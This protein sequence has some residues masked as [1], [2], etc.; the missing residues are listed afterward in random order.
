MPVFTYSELRISHSPNGMCGADIMAHNQKINSGLKRAVIDNQNIVNNSRFEA[1]FDNLLNP[2]DLV[3]NKTGGVIFTEQ[4]GS[5]APL[6]SPDLS[7]LT[8]NVLQMMKEDGEARSGLSSLTKGMNTAV[9]E[10]QNAKDMVERLTNAAGARPSADARSFAQSFLIPL[11]RYLV[12]Y[13]A[14]WDYSQDQTEASGQMIP[15]I[16][17]SWQ[18]YE[19]ECEVTVALTPDES[20]SQAQMLLTM[21]QVISQDPVASQLYGVKER[22]AMFDDIFDA[23]GVSDTQRYM[24]RPDSPEF[25]A[26]NQQVMELQQM[27]QMLQEQLNGVQ[28]WAMTQQVEQGWAQINNTMMDKMEDNVRQDSELAME[29]RQGDRKLD[30]EEMKAKKTN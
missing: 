27:V 21:H 7:P 15:I 2:R 14:Q 5:V 8:F 17:Q 9:L 30:I 13:A 26:Q 23:M 12:K 29:S 16:P 18:G 22:H 24:M 28:T 19:D 6:P 1:V 11:F 4:M 3:E 10:N 25:Q 20:E